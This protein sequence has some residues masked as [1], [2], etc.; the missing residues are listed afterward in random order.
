MTPIHPD[1][2]TAATVRGERLSYAAPFVL[3]SLFLVWYYHFGQRIAANDGLGYDGV[4][5]GRLAQD[6]MK[7]FEEATIADYHVTRTLPSLVIFVSTKASGAALRSIS[8]I[9]T[10]FY[11]YN[12]VLLILGLL[13]WVMISRLLAYNYW[14]YIIGV[15]ALVGNCQNLKIMPYY[16]T[17]T[18]TSAWLLGI[19]AVYGCL[20]GRKV[21]LLACLPFTYFTWPIGCGITL[22]LLA[23]SFHRGDWLRV[24][25][26]ERSVLVFTGVVAAFCAYCYVAYYIGI[27]HGRYTLGEPVFL[28]GLAIALAYIAYVIYASALQRPAVALRVFD[29]KALAAGLLVMFLCGLLKDYIVEAYGLSIHPLS[30][31]RYVADIFR[32]SVKK[33]GVF[34][35]SHIAYLG[36]VWLVCVV[37][38]RRGF[39]GF[40]KHGA[41]TYGALIIVLFFAL[42]AQSRRLIFFYPAVVVFACSA[43][44][45]AIDAKRFS[46]WFAVASL[47]SIVPWLRGGEPT[48]IYFPLNA[49]EAGLEPTGDFSIQLYSM[50]YGTNVSWAG[51]GVGLGVGVVV[52]VIVLRGM[53]LARIKS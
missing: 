51:Y 14:T 31:V 27:A 3:L 48:L 30:F 42:D 23:F 17:L 9:Y 32:F 19:L 22:V 15:W 36:P 37:L 35:M 45:G 43:M 8:D 53:W 34:L 52:T 20:A 16:P 28:A 6:F 18:D 24:S 25:M 33:P 5:Y 50:G 41:G 39:F 13:V 2:L 4:L 46:G 11:V 21:I 40:S 44:R 26:A 12:S 10:A 1:S 47:V 7:P 38:L 29:V 49:A